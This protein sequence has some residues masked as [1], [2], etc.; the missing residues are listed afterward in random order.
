LSAPGRE[1]RLPPVE[2]AVAEKTRPH[3][4]CGD[5]SISTPARALHHLPSYFRFVGVAALGLGLDLWSKHQVFQT[6]GQGHTPVVVIPHVLELQTMLNKG[7]LFGIGAGQT[8]LFLIASACALL[9]VFWMFAQTSARSWALQ[10]ALGGILAGALGNMYDRSFVKLPEESWRGVYMQK[11]GQDAR[12]VVLKV[13]PARAGEHEIIVPSGEV[14]REV[15]FVRDFI[16]IPTTL[17]Q[18]GWIP[19]RL[20][21]KELWPWVF[22]VADMLLVGGVAILAVHLWRERRALPKRARNTVD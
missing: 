22:N 13:Y 11:V 19:A 9:L 2:T 21:G 3:A 18:W 20:S 5:G 1:P 8:T 16:K 12:G 15:G 10:I 14:P 4:S 17:P 7:A 6:L